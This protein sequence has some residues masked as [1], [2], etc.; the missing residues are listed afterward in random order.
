MWSSNKQA[1]NSRWA[2]INKSRVFRSPG[3]PNLGQMVPYLRRLYPPSLGP[4]L[5]GGAGRR[6]CF[7]G[8]WPRLRVCSVVQQQATATSRWALIMI[9]RVRRSPKG[10]NLGRRVPYLRRSY[11]PTLG[12]QLPGG[13]GRR[14]HYPKNGRNG[15]QQ[16]TATAGGP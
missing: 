13:A 12:P 16:A 10:P 6:S 15:Q 14:P 7:S 11:P 9:S 3:G 2:L 1:S 4:Q 8:K 5:P